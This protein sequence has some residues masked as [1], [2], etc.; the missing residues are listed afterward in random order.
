MATEKIKQFWLKFS[1]IKS[2]K[3]EKNVRILTFFLRI[4]ILFFLTEFLLFY[5]KLLK[6]EFFYFF[7]LFKILRKKSQNCKKY[8][9]CDPNPLPL[10]TASN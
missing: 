8:F 6:S 3:T 9:F 5:L 10:K 1:D 2:Q 7:K 4:E